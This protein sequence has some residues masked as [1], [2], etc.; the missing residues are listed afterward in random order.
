MFYVFTLRKL[1]EELL[2]QNKEV[3]QGRGK[4]VFQKNKKTTLKIRETNWILNTGEKKGG[5]PGWQQQ[6]AS[7]GNNQAVGEMS[8]AGAGSWKK[9]K[10]RM[11]RQERGEETE[12]GHMQ[13]DVSVKFKNCYSESKISARRRV[14]ETVILKMVHLLVRQS[15]I[16]GSEKLFK[17]VYLHWFHKESV[18]CKTHWQFWMKTL[19]SLGGRE[20]LGSSH[21]MTSF[22]SG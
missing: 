1:L 17:N 10:D 16:L 3:N 4:K 22:L 13:T 8:R 15:S 9:C 12:W 11:Q 19:R 6:Q 14:F 21:R 18:V 2:Q 7:A 5:F 20:D